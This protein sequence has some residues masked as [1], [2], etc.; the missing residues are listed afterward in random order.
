MNRLTI[1]L[2]A[3]HDNIRT[4]DRWVHNHGASWS[5]V[6]K[7]LCGHRSTLRCLQ[8]MG[9]HSMADSRM[10]NLK[11]IESLPGD[12]EAW[13]LRLPHLPVVPDV[14]RLSDVSL[15]SEIDVIEALNVEAGRQGKLH[16]IIIMLELGDLR[17]GVLPG[18]LVGFYEH[19]FELPNIEV[20]GVGS[21]LGCL[22]GA[23]PSIDQFA[24]LSLYHE[25]LELKFGRSLPVISGGTSAALPLLRSGAL[26]KTINHF[27]IGDSAFLGTDLIHGGVL[28]G[29]RGDAITLE[30]EVVEV[31]EKGLRPMGET[32]DMMPFE[33]LGTP[34]TAPGARGHRAVITVGQLDTVVSGLT[35]I[36]PSYRLV[37][38]SSDLSVVNLGDNPH[39]IKVGDTLRFRPSYGAFVRLMMDPYIPKHLIANHELREALRAEATEFE[40]PPVLAESESPLEIAPDALKQS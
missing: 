6:T 39:G 36:E 20:L 22:S 4:I 19:V 7:T 18:S 30:V 14:V 35:P 21:N 27:R 33:A 2:Q 15:N 10:D 24:Q 25:L 29:L 31:K 12:V 11:A 5:L 16:R 34:E 32:T 17:E 3:L 8:A 40:V 38:A 1:D 37:G 9:V 28:E 13:Y 26:P 23:V